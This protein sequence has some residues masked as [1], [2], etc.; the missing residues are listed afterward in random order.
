MCYKHNVIWGKGDLP[1]EVGLVG[2]ACLG[3]GSIAA[4]LEGT[5][6]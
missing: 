2:E 3:W 4:S 1:G 6:A 5:V